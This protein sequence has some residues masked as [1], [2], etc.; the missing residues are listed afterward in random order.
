MRTLVGVDY[1]E[2]DALADF[3]AARAGERLA[4]GVDPSTAISILITA[5]RDGLSL[6][7]TEREMQRVALLFADHAHYRAEWAPVNRLPRPLRWPIQARADA[8]HIVNGGGGPSSA[9]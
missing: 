1:W 7:A 6:E 9:R 5:Y 8:D 2:L 4:G 3:L